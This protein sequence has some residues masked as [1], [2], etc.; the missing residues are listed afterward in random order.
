M[1]E[2]HNIL[3]KGNTSIFSTPT[4]PTRRWGKIHLK[5]STTDINSINRGIDK[6]KAKGIVCRKRR[7]LPSELKFK[8]VGKFYKIEYKG[9]I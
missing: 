8:N 5:H 6:L 7:D 3:V 4:F 2:L 1:T 9:N